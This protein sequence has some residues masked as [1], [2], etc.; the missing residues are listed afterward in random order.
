MFVWLVGNEGV[1]VV[2]S[3]DW[4]I[5]RARLS[6]ASMMTTLDPVTQVSATAVNAAAREVYDFLQNPDGPLRK[7]IAAMSD[8]AVHFVS[9]VWCRAGCGAVKYRKESESSQVAGMTVE[10]FQAA[11]RGRLCERPASA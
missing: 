2:Q 3:R 5:K 7:F 6:Q 9:S 8:G 4:P 1:A 10:E 11:I